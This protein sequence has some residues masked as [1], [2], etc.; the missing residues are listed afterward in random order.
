[1]NTRSLLA[2]LIAALV[3]GGVVG[4]ALL[5]GTVLSKSQ[6]GGPPMSPDE[7]AELM[8]VS[9]QQAAQWG[10]ISRFGRTGRIQSVEAKGETVAVA[11]PRGLLQAKVGEG[12]TIRKAK[13]G[14]ETPL[15]FEDLQAGMLITVN[16]PIGEAE[17]TEILVVPE[18]EGGFDIKPATGPGPHQVPVFP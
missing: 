1:M 13:K 8:K 2:L 11:T 6:G 3:L 12:T 17:A 9:K 15:A 7:A 5:V 14:E 16:G 4:A 18:G 10:F